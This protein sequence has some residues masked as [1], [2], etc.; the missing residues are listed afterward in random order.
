[1][2]IS[3]GQKEVLIKIL[4]SKNEKKLSLDEYIDKICAEFA[5]VNH[6]KISDEVQ[7]LYLFILENFKISK[8]ELINLI[9]SKIEKIELE[10]AVNSEEIYLKIKGENAKISPNLSSSFDSVDFKAI[11]LIDDS[12]YW[13]G[14]EYNEKLQTTLKETIKEFMSGEIGRKNIAESLAEKLKGVVKENASIKYFEGVADNIINQN[15]NL[16]MVLNADE[17]VEFFKV[18]ARMD[19]KTSAICRSMHGRLIPAKHLQKQAK[20]LLGAKSMADKKNAAVWMSGEYLGR[21][22]KMPS[23]FGLPPYH[24]HCR[25]M[26]VPV[27]V[28]KNEDTGE[29]Y[30]GVKS[31]DEAI[32]HI[33]KMGVERYADEN[34]Y[35]HSA[36]S[37][38]RKIMPQDTIKALNSIVKIAPHKDFADRY[39]AMS[40]NGYFMVFKGDY[41]YNIFKPERNLDKY[42]KDSAIKEKTEIIKWKF[43]QL[44]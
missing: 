3:K 29:A 32:R 10:T 1:M 40:Q 25:T 28:N 18:M 41:L 13:L 44:V 16:N 4:K 2:R 31:D 33:D 24:F 14:N 12:F 26:I 38:K 9:N 37:S 27:Y 22:D 15:R 11:K 5:K 35:K 34:T 36:S 17:E 20:N 39:V 30:T 43:I 19:N 42:F 23:D 21:S 6:A 8:D 7:N